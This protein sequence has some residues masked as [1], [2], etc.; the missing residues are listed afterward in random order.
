M[1]QDAVASGLFGGIEGFIH[2]LD[3]GMAVGGLLVQ[4]GDANA[5]GKGDLAR[6]GGYFG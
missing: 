4:A 1:Q 2:I 3:E 6:L 5:D